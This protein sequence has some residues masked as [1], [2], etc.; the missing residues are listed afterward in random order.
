MSVSKFIAGGCVIL[1]LAVGCGKSDEGGATGGSFQKRFDSAMNVSNPDQRSRKLMKLAYD[2]KQGKDSA[3][4]QRSLK[5]ATKSAEKMTD[6]I[7]RSSL[8]TQLA[9]TQAQLDN[10][11]EARDALRI[12]KKAIDEIESVESQANALCAVA[13]VEGAQL[14]KADDAV[15]TL[16]DVE[17]KA[18]TVDDVV[19]KINVLATAA[20]TYAQ[21]D[22]KKDVQRVISKALQMARDLTDSGDRTNALNLVAKAQIA[23]KLPK[24]AADTLVLAADSGRTIS[25]KYSQAL[26]LADVAESLSKANKSADAHQLLEEADKGANAITEPDLQQQAMKRVRELMGELPKG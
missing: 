22:E 25:N 26:A 20:R 6:S 10:P 3:G 16:R 2:Q 14:D 13:E 21:L 18:D 9:S 7:G 11:S 8:F 5:E 24:E 4:S 17:K 23:M 1:V 15:D 19:G 12:A